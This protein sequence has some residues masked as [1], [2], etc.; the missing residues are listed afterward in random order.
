MRDVVP[1]TIVLIFSSCL[2]NCIDISG[3]CPLA[4]DDVKPPFDIRPSLTLP[5][6]SLSS[7]KLPWQALIKIDVNGQP[8][9]CGGS[10]ISAKKVLTA[11]HG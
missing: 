11:G 4:D 3:N 5:L 2:V 7:G 1:L 10:L 6:S 8:W 9:M